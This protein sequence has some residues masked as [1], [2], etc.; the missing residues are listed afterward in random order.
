MSDKKR[1]QTSKA[2]EEWKAADY[3]DL[4]TDAVNDLLNADESNSPKVSRAELRKYTAK[5]GG[6]RL[7]DWVKLLFIKWWFS[8]A[9]CFFILWG[10]GAMVPNV[11]DQLVITGLALGF[12]TDLLTNN[13]L[14]FLAK[15]EGANDRW[16]MHHR[17]GFWSLPLNILHAGAV[18][19][20]VY[21][22][23]NALN[24]ALIALRGLPGD[25][26]PLGVEPI[27]F[28]LLCL[29]FDMMLIGIKH[30]FQ[31][32][33]ADAKQKASAGRS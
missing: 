10:L 17:K 27:L 8:A 19:F 28:G 11:L 23:Y 20:L 16:M 22:A 4:K 6:L 1:K 24:R 14:R 5:R 15:T 18:L 31:K 30:G 25:A 13:V 2:R 32:I 3:Y 21:T 9:V 33:M 26:V 12:V 29:G 7:G